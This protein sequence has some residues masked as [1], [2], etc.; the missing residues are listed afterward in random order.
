MLNKNH[1]PVMIREV[2]QYLNINSSG[3]YVDAT[4]GMGG[5]SNAILNK[6]V[7]GTLY[8]FDQD[9]QAIRQCQKRFINYKNIFLINKNFSFLYDELLARNVNRID[10]IVFDL[11]LSLLQI[12]DN[13]RG[14]S[15]LRNNIL[16]MRMDCN[17]P[18]TAQYILNNYSLENLQNIFQIYGEEPKSRLI[19]KEIIK[20]RPFYRTAELV[21]ITDKFKNPYNNRGGAKEA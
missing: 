16:D 13:E 5:H 14:F 21:N 2:V 8:S 20:N 11:G 15:Y 9:I 18:I 19:A 10:G 6:L 4:L 17:N 1:I 12:N 7:D 3:V